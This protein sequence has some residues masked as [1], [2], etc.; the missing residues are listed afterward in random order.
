MKNYTMWN[1]SNHII[2]LE[3]SKWNYSRVIKECFERDG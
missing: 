2:I 1:S 3:N